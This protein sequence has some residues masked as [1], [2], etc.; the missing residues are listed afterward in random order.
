MEWRIWITKWFLF[1]SDIQDYIEYINKKH[2]TLTTIPPIH[3]Y[4]NRINNRLVFK[5]KDGYKVELQTPETIKLFGSTKNK[6]IDKIKNG[7]ISSLEEVEVVLIQYNL[8]DNQYQ[9]K[10]EVSKTFNPNKY[11]AY[12]LNVE[13]SNLVYFKTYNT[14]FDKVIIKFADQNDR[15]LEIE[16]K[17]NLTLLIKK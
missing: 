12:L 10:Y 4:I 11:Y 15:P 6:R 17:V 9:Q 16:D 3:V 14:E 1:C 8:V 13:P 7:G 5:I 2:E